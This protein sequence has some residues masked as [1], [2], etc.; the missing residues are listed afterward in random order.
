MRH[1]HVRV[2][3]TDRQ[4]SPGGVHL[5]VGK[6]PRQSGTRLFHKTEI[7]FLRGLHTRISMR[8]RAGPVVRSPATFRN[9]QAETAGNCTVLG[10]RESDASNG[11][12]W[13]RPKTEAASLATSFNRS[14]RDMYTYLDT[15]Q[16]STSCES[17]PS[18]GTEA[19]RSRHAFAGCRNEQSR[20]GGT[21]TRA[22]IAGFGRHWLPRIWHRSSISEPRENRWWTGSCGPNLRHQVEH[23]GIA[24]SS[25]HP[26]PRRAAE[27]ERRARKCMTK[28]LE[29]RQ[30]Q[31]LRCLH[32]KKMPC[33]HSLPSPKLS[34]DAGDSD[35]SLPIRSW[36]DLCTTTAFRGFLHW[37]KAATPKAKTPFARGCEWARKKTGKQI[38][39]PRSDTPRRLFGREAQTLRAAAARAARGSSSSSEA[40]LPAGEAAST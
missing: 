31:G 28:N 5:G 34:A 17:K 21:S 39:K 1:G 19:P 4:Q 27:K 11:S 13:A 23:K 16:G 30:S 15:S 22:P 7:S 37:S 35:R 14:R 18:G 38:P 26:R 10:G 9:W 40:G 33:R 32:A 3:I 20:S 2:E 8:A 24:A 36:A 29:F 25:R 12:N 6:R